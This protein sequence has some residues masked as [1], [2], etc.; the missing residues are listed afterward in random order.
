MPVNPPTSRQSGFS[1]IELLIGMLIALEILVVALT[2]FDV[3]NRMARLQL[4]ITD[5][6]QSLR[7]AQYDMV[8]TTRMAGRGG[9]PADFRVDPDDL[10]VPWLRGLAVES[11]DNVLDGGDNEVALGT[12]DPVALP[13]TDILTVRGC[14]S[15]ILFQM[16]AANPADFTPTS[17]VVHRNLPNGRSQDLSA[18]LET[19]FSSPMLLQSSVSRGQYA[20]AEVTA[21]AGTI[22]DV[23]LTITFTSALSP[24][25][26][27]VAVPPAGFVPGFA[28]ALEEYRYYVRQNFETPGDNATPLKPR[29]TRA[30]MIPGTEM[31]H[32]G[33]AANLVLDLADDI[34]DLQVA[35]GFDTDHDSAA[36]GVG[37]FDDDTDALGVDDVFY[38]GADDDAR[39][40]DDWLGNS[41][42]DNPADAEYRVN[43]AIPA[44]A[45]RLYYVRISTLV[46]TA[47][48]DPRFVAPDFDP[49]AGEDFIENNDYDAA[50]ADVFKTP[51]NRQYRHRL[52]RTVV[53][54]RNI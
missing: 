48:R 49:I 50:P 22:Q 1:L 14:L 11:R 7:V 30:R 45:V 51:E 42:A 17:L 24:P 44:R 46:R 15:G 6:Q 18:L 31:P 16:D 8:R 40:T 33:A 13:G 23:T 5:M 28:C 47:R 41:S 3:H 34:F 19:G 54:L 38:E 2:V 10:S 32:A 52:L 35:L 37:S 25:N 39:G 29:L 12:A 9:L 26:P 27:L 53:D 21:V 4:Q 43:A 36:S 20:V